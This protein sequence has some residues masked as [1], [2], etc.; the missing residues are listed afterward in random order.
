MSEEVTLTEA[1]RATRSLPA[2]RGKVRTA[3]TESPRSRVSL[4]LLCNYDARMTG[5]IS[6]GHPVPPNPENSNTHDIFRY[7]PNTSK[8]FQNIQI[9]IVSFGKF[10]DLRQWLEFPATQKKIYEHLSEKSQMSANTQ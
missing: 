4:L 5:E 1:E 3:P 9:L 2:P 8:Q 10:T 7:T 6:E